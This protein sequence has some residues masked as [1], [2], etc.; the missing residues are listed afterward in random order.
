MKVK[1]DREETSYA[2][3]KKGR[4]VKG[5]GKTRLSAK[6]LFSPLERKFRNGEKRSGRRSLPKMRGKTGTEKMENVSIGPYR[7]HMALTKK[8]VLRRSRERRNNEG[9]SEGRESRDNA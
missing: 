4:R 8:G 7:L 9:C 1:T 2:V 3:S 5:T 6:R